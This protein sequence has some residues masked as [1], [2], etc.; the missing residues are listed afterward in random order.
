MIAFSLK[1]PRKGLPR[2]S[3]S[4]S[5]RLQPFGF[6]QDKLQASLLSTSPPSPLQLEMGGPAGQGEVKMGTPK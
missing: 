3:F 5:K 1:M 2:K 6:A 4:F